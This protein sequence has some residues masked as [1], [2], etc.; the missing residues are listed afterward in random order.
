MGDEME[1]VYKKTTID[2]NQKRAISWKIAK[3]I[4]MIVLVVLAV[5]VFGFVTR[6]LWNWLVP[7]IFGLRA[8]T[9]W[10]AIGLC[11]LSK[12]LFGGFHKHGGG[13]GRGW[14]R[15]M[16]QRWAAMS[17]EERERFRAGMRNRCDWRG[18]GR[19]SD[20]MKA[21]ETAAGTAE[22]GVA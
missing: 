10:Q 13:G 11:V 8:I 9:F 12:I 22:K 7:G 16:E 2:W 19:F 20:E 17:D 21:E 4:K 6:E 15:R 14:R 3:I 1:D 18:R 5:A